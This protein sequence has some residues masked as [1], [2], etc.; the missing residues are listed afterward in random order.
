MELKYKDTAAQ[1]KD[2]DQK[3]GIV[4]GYLSV[5]G[6]KDSDGDIITKGAFAKTLSENKS[7]IAYLW[8]HDITKPIGK[9]L[10]L[11]EDEKGLFY[12][13]QMS[14]SSL[15]R[16][17]L[18]LMEEGILKENSIGFNIIKGKEMEDHYQISEIKLWEGSVVTIAANPK[19]M[20]D[21]VKSEAEKT[22]IIAERLGKLEN[23][24]RKG[25]LTDESYRLIEY[26]ISQIKNI[27]S[28]EI[29]PEIPLKAEEPM[30]SL[31][32]FNKYLKS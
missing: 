10:D 29:E 26:E 12:T 18:T 20:I 9:F 11:N 7:R 3:S 5:F 4:S 13:A 30:F 28:L 27:A 15:G 16:D 25:N 17:A 19:A 1:F 14:K 24:M 23:F 6:N 22:N 21:S 8:Q 2:I 32:K 31:E